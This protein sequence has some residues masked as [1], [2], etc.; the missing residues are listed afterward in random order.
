MT[1]SKESIFGLVVEHLKQ[2]LTD[3][4]HFPFGFHSMQ[5][6]LWWIT[7]P[8]LSLILVTTHN[9]DQN[10]LLFLYIVLVKDSLT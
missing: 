3:Q 7:D 4:L 1:S 10:H 5:E 9:Y 6:A 8:L 2:L